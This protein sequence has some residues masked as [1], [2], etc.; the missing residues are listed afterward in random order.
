MPH[1]RHI[2]LHFR[3]CRHCS[4]CNSHWLAPPLS[5]PFPPAA[6]CAATR[7]ERGIKNRLDNATCDHVSRRSCKQITQLL[8]QLGADNTPKPAATTFHLADCTVAC[9]WGVYCRAW[10]ELAALNVCLEARTHRFHLAGS[11]ACQDL[12]PETNCDTASTRPAL[13]NLHFASH[14]TN[15]LDTPNKK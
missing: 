3:L 5:S 6:F 14:C 8:W 10:H 15:D 9:V 11:E 7:K 13:F 12:C 4:I 1:N 2:A